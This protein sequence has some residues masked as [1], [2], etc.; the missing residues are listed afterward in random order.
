MVMT[1]VQA[2]L[3]VAAFLCSLVTGLLFAFA[4]VVMPGLRTLADGDFIRAFQ[5]IDRVIQRNQPLFLIVWMGSVLA[6]VTAA[7]VGTWALD[8]VE[9]LLTIAAALVY[10]CGVQAPTFAVNIPLNNRLQALNVAAMSEADR[11][12]A[13]REFEARWNRWNVFRTVCASA[14]SFLLILSLA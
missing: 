7:V 3:V 10:L 13:R 4:V 14:T 12:R 1:F 5:V 11:R 2:A 6:L 8:G 9:R